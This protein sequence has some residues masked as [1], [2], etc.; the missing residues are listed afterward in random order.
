MKKASTAND[1]SDADQ[2]A[3]DP[4]EFFG[5]I[6]GDKVKAGK[7]D[8]DWNGMIVRDAVNVI[9]GY[10]GTGKSSL[11][12]R[13]G[14]MIC[15]GLKF[16][17]SSAKPRKGKCLWVGTEESF[18]NAVL[19][20]WIANGGKTSD[21]MTLDFSDVGQH[22][23]MLLPDQ[24]QR[25]VSLL[26]HLDI[27]YLALDPFSALLNPSIDTRNEQQM[28]LYMQ[29]LAESCARASVTAL[30]SRHFRKGKALN[31]LDAGIGS[32]AIGN[33]ARSVLRADRDKEDSS[34][35]YLTCIS[36]NAG[37]AEG[38]MEYSLVPNDANVFAVKFGNRV[39]KTIEDITEDIDDDA[40]EDEKVDAR[41][42]LLEILKNGKVSY[43]DIEAE[44]KS[45]GICARTLRNVK[46]KFK[47]KSRRYPPPGGGTTIWYW[48]PPKPEDV[49]QK[50]KPKK[51]PSK[52]K[53]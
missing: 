35:C 30:V 22:G 48:L 46:K 3:F 14:V 20:R 38:S 52:P 34:I 1:Q 45:A 12:A 29:S 33:V 11:L 26:Q 10:K 15:A 4:I 47:I 5:I 16:P 40:T 6:Q 43:N 41:T 32:V 36:C 37:K 24:Q 44:G 53:K 28:R 13:I 18:P 23:R 39:D 19:P 17:E 8:F 31:L 9:D 27:R 50:T 25:F 42:L 49:V 51:K 7:V 21:I 2:E